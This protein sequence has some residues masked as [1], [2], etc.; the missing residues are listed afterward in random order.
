MRIGFIGAGIVGTSLA[1]LLE[2]RGYEVSDV[3]DKSKTQLK[4]F[5]GMLPRCRSHVSNQGVVDGA[6][7]VFL[8]VP[9]DSIGSMVQELKWRPGQAVVHCSGAA[10]SGI[11]EP[12]QT[13]HT[14]HSGRLPSPRRVPMGRCRGRNPGGGRPASGGR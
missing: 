11:L 2:K 6:E 3:A 10:S 9:D 13:R 12:A 1:A 8:T 14:G 7:T 5:A 4:S